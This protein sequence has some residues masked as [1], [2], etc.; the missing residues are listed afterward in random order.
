MLSFRERSALV[1][2]FSKRKFFAGQREI[3]SSRVVTR[4]LVDF[5]R[6]HPDFPLPPPQSLVWRRWYRL[7]WPDAKASSMEAIAGLLVAGKGDRLPI[8]YFTEGGRPVLI[9]RIIDY[10]KTRQ[11]H[12]CDARCRN[13]KRGDCECA[14]GGEFHGCDAMSAG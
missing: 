13:A 1:E 5:R 10:K 2:S 8:T 11:P 12:K 4:D 9:D 14:C 7:R 6:T 3:E